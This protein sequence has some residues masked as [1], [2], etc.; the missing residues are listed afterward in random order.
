M[1]GKERITAAV[2]HR[3]GEVPIE[4]GGFP[5][6][7]IHSSIVAA[8]RDYYG[9]EKRS[10]K[11]YEPY[12]M[13]G[14]IDDDLKDVLGIDSDY[15]WSPYT[16]YGF[17]LENWKEWRTPWGQE[18]LVPGDFN[19]TL[20]ESGDVLIYPEGDTSVSPS[21]RMPESGFFFDSI[22]RQPP[23]VEEELN[24]EDNL[25]E[26]GP[27]D[28]VSLDHYRREVDRLKDSG[29]YIVANFGGTALGDIACVPAP[30]L[31]FP[32]GIRDV[33]E[34]YISTAVRQDYVR[35]IFDRQSEIAIE[36][37]KK[38]YD[39]VGDV[40]QAAYICGTDFGTQNGPFC[41][42][43]LF[44]QLWAPF[45]RRINDWIHE[46][47]GWKCFKH[48]CGGIEP[49]IGQ[50]IEVGFDILN[51]LQFSASGMDPRAI[52]ERYGKSLTFWGGGVDTQKTLPFGTP[53][54]VRKEV[55][56]RC[57][58][59][60]ENGGFVFNTIHNVQ[61]GTPVENFVAMIDAVRD[62]NQGRID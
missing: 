55:Q 35:E 54:D 22:V 8:L 30:G 4:F 5:T 46:H 9:L 20:G 50:M 43:S 31:K 38:I 62:F 12:Q 37:L 16:F 40:V 23:I 59:L 60:S 3:S 26:F 19:T 10:V 13:L 6:T 14:E 45:Y 51:P 25:E 2:E 57:A 41:D 52:K 49:F 21:A 28:Q 29:R 27:I 53:K 15:I 24:V 39:V 44:G 1:N 34:W 33:T 61:A 42:P 47:T 17:R 48:S 36:N 58:I 11:I 32:K 18:V 7:G 56:E